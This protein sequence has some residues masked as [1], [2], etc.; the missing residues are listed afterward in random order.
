MQGRGLPWW[1]GRGSAISFAALLALGTYWSLAGRSTAAP[2]SLTRRESSGVSR[3]APPD[4]RLPPA[5]ASASERELEGLGR[6]AA[7][8]LPEVGSALPAHSAERAVDGSGQPH[9]LTV[10]HRR[11]FEE[12]NAIGALSGAMDQGDV[13]ALRRLNARYRQQY[14]ED[15]H[16]L[17]EGYE[18]IAACLEDRT[19]QVIEAARSFWQVHR[20][21]QLRRH[22][23]RHCLEERA[24]DVALVRRA[25][26]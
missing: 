4:P 14:P 2:E 20:A 11:I 18:L 22:V 8:A 13:A 7:R 21:S 6:G 25:P 1:G 10:R 9:P 19:P 23:R 26:E 15:E 16:D 17:Q 24:A 12:N 5:Q 3:R